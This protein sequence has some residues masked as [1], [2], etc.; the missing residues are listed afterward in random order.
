MCGSVKHVPATPLQRAPSLKLPP[1]L[2]PFTPTW[3]GALQESFFGPLADW[4]GSFL[5]FSAAVNLLVACAAVLLGL[6]GTCA[7]TLCWLQAR[8]RH[9]YT[10]G[11]LH[12][13]MSQVRLQPPQPSPA[14][15]WYG[16][17]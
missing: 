17:V 10:V 4:L 12:A 5:P 8:R 1:S 11:G 16:C 14:S 6:L 9:R 13:G 3:F 7:G 15:G 2:L